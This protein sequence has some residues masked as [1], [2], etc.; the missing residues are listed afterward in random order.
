MLSTT[1]WGNKMR[2]LLAAV[3]LLVAAPAARADQSSCI[4]CIQNSAT[5]QNAQMN[6]GTATIRG[7]LTVG[8][9][10]ISSITASTMTADVF[11]GSGTS[12]TDL[13]AS[14]I[15]R[16]LVPSSRVV[17]A[18]PNITSIGTLTSGVW[19]GSII[20][21]Q[22]GGTGQN[23]VTSLQGSLPYFNGTGTMATLPPGNAESILQTNGAGQN[24][25][26]TSSP[27]VSGL[28]ITN[29][30]QANLQ[31]GVLASGITV[32]DSALSVVS[33]SKV[34][35]NIPG[36]AANITG[37]LSLSQLTAG[38]L[39]TAIPASS[40]TVTGATPGYYGGPGQAIL[41]NLRSDGRLASIS[42]S[43][44]SVP[45]SSIQPGV[46]PAGVYLPANQVLAGSLLST[47]I[48][49]S[50]SAT[51]VTAGSYGGSAQTL[52]ATVQGDGRLSLLSQAS[53]AL[54]ANQ[55]LAGA[56][57][58]GV[59]VRAVDVSAG[60]L[61][62]NVIASSVAATTVHAGTYGSAT[63]VPSI[64]IAPDGRVT[65][66]SFSN[67]S[68]LS[69]SAAVTDQ[70]NGWS[71]S[72]TSFSSWT[73]LQSI[74]APV[75]AAGTLSGN[76]AA[77]TALTPSNLS[78][79]ALPSTVI[80]SS[81]AANTS[82]SMTG[83]STTLTTK[84]SVT[85][86][87]FF[88]D[89]SHLTG[90]SASPTGAAGG[91]LAGT[92]PNPIIGS[93]V[94]VAT[95]I[96]NGVLTNTQM[97][98][99]TF[100]NITIPAAN[101][102]AGSLGAS[103]IASSWAANASI[104]LAGPSASF[105]TQSSAT[106]SAFFGDGSHLANI[107]AATIPNTISSSF[108]ITS[109][110]GLGVT[111]GPIQFGTG[112]YSEGVGNGSVV[113]NARGT[114]AVDLQTFRTSASQVASGNYSHIGGGINNECTGIYCVCNGGNG[115]RVDEAYAWNGGGTNNTMFSGATASFN[116]GGEGNSISARDSGTFGANNT[117]TSV[118]Q[119][120]MVMGQYGQASSSGSFVY[121]DLSATN[122]NNYVSHGY[123]TA[124]FQA[125]GGFY[126]DNSS[127]TVTGPV[128]GSTFFGDGSHLTGIP[129]TGS[130]SGFYVPYTGAT[131]NVVLGN[132]NLSTS[133][134][135]SAA[136]AVI[137]SSAT[138]L[139][140]FSA[141]GTALVVTA[142]TVSLFGSTVTVLSNGFVGIG[143]NTPTGQLS[144]HAN[145]LDTVSLN[146]YGTSPLSLLI[147][148]G[149]SGTKDAPTALAAGKSWGQIQWNG[150]GTSAF[151]GSRAAIIVTSTE[152]FTDTAQG[153]TM[154]LQT[155]RTGTVVS[156]THLFIGADGQTGIGEGGSV[157]APTAIVEISSAP[158]NTA[159]NVNLF[160]ISSG[161]A[162][163]TKMVTV[164]I[165]GGM[166]LNGG[167]PL[168]VASTITVQGN[169]FSVGASSLVV[170]GGKV[171]VGTTA[172]T[173]AL[174]VYGV[175][176]SSTTQGTISCNAGTPT[177]SA[178]CTDQ[179][180]TFAAGTLATAC[181]YTF[182]QTLTQVPDCIAG[183]NAAT[184][185][186]VSVTS[187]SNTSITIT[188]AAALT[189]DNVTFICGQAP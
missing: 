22:Y 100:S 156:A 57:T 28:N 161:T 65:A 52:L 27:S 173:T 7:T 135:I 188:A 177:L 125:T 104:S 21:T 3:A 73:F 139:G 150:Y 43:T 64:T 174:S 5:P 186:A 6:I 172:P 176:T 130:I 159:A 77:I 126:I 75:V 82:I 48:A 133:Y 25:V 149:A 154:G 147:L 158:G 13:N 79:G 92:Y 106:A 15:T 96:A 131:S 152:A 19:N 49:S 134:G 101:V 137:T 17:G 38:T 121:S 127:L 56:L 67:I 41:L 122:S 35:G 164:S 62:S 16:G 83:P 74:S 136:T 84:S 116:P 33:A 2:N 141:S 167:T 71:H 93:Q 102:A 26:W 162:A 108:T 9:I 113:G 166:H 39:P 68:S 85:A 78:A 132:N 187:P 151:G 189:G 94:I 181:T 63:S 145:N 142:S 103:V 37:N 72:Q 119:Y 99:G 146:A 30:P 97:A 155:T 90:L 40:I 29:I 55:V 178:T 110:S 45:V 24:P 185:I 32:P 54:P 81:W 31:T 89:G 124:N 91:N 144:T 58:A 143:T 170:T 87:A 140:N 44:F 153:T 11:I 69:T 95:H 76:G 114:G 42:Q 157:G 105:T 66:A 47:V 23:F 80:G 111:S 160:R 70:D 107:S 112:I 117:I 98:A 182:S 50:V 175:I 118:A 148:R 123:N 10:N 20:G 109:A 61:P 8:A 88:G 163:G 36:N 51:A 179:H 138:V 171:G 169:A 180:C 86:S 115:N 168:T 12:L 1:K 46:L 34:S 129:S 165:L 4:T 128:T 184:P 18:Y 53:I 120:S 183:T 60:V 14:N 59:T